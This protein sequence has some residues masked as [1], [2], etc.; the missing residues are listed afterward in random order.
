MAADPTF[1]GKPGQLDGA[2]DHGVDP[3]GFLCRECKMY[4]NPNVRRL[5]C[6]TKGGDTDG[7]AKACLYGGR[8]T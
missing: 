3:R 7:R 4:L 5:Y 8:R 1:R 2:I 6:S